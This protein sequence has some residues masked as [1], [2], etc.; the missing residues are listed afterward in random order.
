[1]NNYLSKK[2]STISF[3]GTVLVV[4]LHSSSGNGDVLKILNLNGYIQNLFS[5]GIARIAV[6]MFFL[7]SGYLFFRNI[8]P[9][10]YFFINKYK[11]RFKTL[12]IPFIFWSITWNL[13]YYVLTL[14]PYTN[15]IIKWSFEF[16]IKSVIDVVFINPKA[17]QLWFL[18][19]LIAYVILTPLIYISIKKLSLKTLI[20]FFILWILNINFGLSSEGFLFFLCGSYIAINKKSL[21]KVNN[22]VLFILT[23]ICCALLLIKTYIFMNDFNNIFH[24]IFIVMGIIVIWY[25]Y[26]YYSNLIDRQKYLEYL[27]EFNF[28][29]YLT[30]EPI[31]TIVKKTLELI[32]NSKNSY[33]VFIFF[34]APIITIAI[35]VLIGGLIKRY[36]SAIYTL[37]IGGRIGNKIETIKIIA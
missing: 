37:I 1:M 30:H 31:L 28:F 23:I 12:V 17:Y 29:I 5:N 14:I 15:N 24:K 36:L 7:I 33:D 8:V 6:P 27:I 13:F 10:R 11:S 35:C 2:I 26:D 19:D 21:P 20:P 3:V 34:L 18:R 9:T 16:T 25:G 32:T 22:Q 4:L